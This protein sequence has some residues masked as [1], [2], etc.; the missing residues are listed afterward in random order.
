MYKILRLLVPVLTG[1]LVVLGIFKTDELIRDM[2]TFNFSMNTTDM[3]NVL[4]YYVIIPVAILLSIIIQWLVIQPLIRKLEKSYTL[5]RLK[6]I[7]F[8]ILISALLSGVVGFIFWKKTL[9]WGDVVIAV[10]VSFILLFVYFI[11]TALVTKGLTKFQTE[12][13]HTTPEG[14]AEGDNML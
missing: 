9:S 7:H 12:S 2:A 10:I 3:T 4:F 11:I 5:M 13:K 6:L 8:V 1:I 14:K